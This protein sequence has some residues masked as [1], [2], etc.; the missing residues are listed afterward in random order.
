[1]D[2]LE[3]I[4]ATK[5]EELPA[6][7]SAVDAAIANYSSELLHT[8]K[9]SLGEALLKSN[10]GIIAEFKR[11]SPQKGG[12]KKTGVPILS[13]SVTKRMELRHCQSLLTYSILVGKMVLFV[14]REIRVLH[15]LS[16][17]RILSSTRCNSMQQPF[18][19][20]LPYCSLLLV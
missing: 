3:H 8:S 6:I 1:M 20:H 14:K 2:I 5:R 7:R 9:P 17:I 15:C 13:R 11:R 4:I 19:V 18:V 16:Y 12:S 10:T